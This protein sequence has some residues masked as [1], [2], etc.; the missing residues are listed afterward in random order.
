M[1]SNLRTGNLPLKQGMSS[2]IVRGVPV[3]GTAPQATATPMPACQPVRDACCAVTERF[4]AA[5]LS[6][7]CARVDNR[8]P[9]SLQLACA[10]RCDKGDQRARATEGQ[11][12]LACQQL[13][14]NS[15]QEA[16]VTNRPS[17]CFSTQPVARASRPP[18]SQA[19]LPNS[20]ESAWAPLQSWL[21]A[22]LSLAGRRV[23][24]QLRMGQKVFLARHGERADLADPRWAETAEVCVD[25]GQQ[26]IDTAQSHQY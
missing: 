5:A 9:H 7:C 4:S 17:G 11:R 22:P 10:P 16:C 23:L 2:C 20:S 8:R 3:V 26:D 18:S 13:A 12:G 1:W 15:E 6:D 14:A 25:Q 21:P 24:Q 19:S